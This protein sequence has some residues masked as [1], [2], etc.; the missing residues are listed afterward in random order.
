M[1][2]MRVRNG[3]LCTEERYKRKGEKSE[4]LNGAESETENANLKLKEEMETTN[5]EREGE[6]L[7]GQLLEWTPASLVLYCKTFG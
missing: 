6:M 2:L 1:L 7:R 4:S 5:R 3:P